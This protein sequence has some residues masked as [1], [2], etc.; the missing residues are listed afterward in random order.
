MSQDKPMN[1]FE[2]HDAARKAKV[3][4][5]NLDLTIGQRMSKFR[6][7]GNT[8][9]GDTPAQGNVW[10]RREAQLKAQQEALPVAPEKKPTTAGGTV[11]DPALAALK[12]ASDAS[13]AAARAAKI[14]TETVFERI[15]DREASA[16]AREWCLKTE[17]FFPSEWN[18]QQL[19]AIINAFGLPTLFSSF[20]AALEYAERN[21][22]VE[23]RTRRRGEPAP[24]AFNPP[25]DENVDEDVQV[26]QR[27][28]LHDAAV[29]RGLR[30]LSMEELKARADAERKRG[31]R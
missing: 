27:R 31:I 21:N 9:E 29:V 13:R 12:A 23:G 6:S 10:K 16:I 26:R 15:P 3:E 14:P 8:S 25:Q 30:S 28:T 20:D 2:K 4:D 7:G 24:V 19:I 17:R 1:R 18:S 5:A 22:H 11:L